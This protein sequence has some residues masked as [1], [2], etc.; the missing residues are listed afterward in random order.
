ML[1]FSQAKGIL[2]CVGS[3]PRLSPK[4][5]NLK[6]LADIM[7]ILSHILAFA[8]LASLAM[9]CA[10]LLFSA[11][12]PALLGLLA[13]ALFGFTAVKINPEV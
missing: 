13:F 2:L 9:G 5:H 10:F 8:S 12:V 7:K 6:M 1:A 4:S 11:P 3:W